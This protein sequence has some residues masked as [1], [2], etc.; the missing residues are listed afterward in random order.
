M[1]NKTRFRISL[2]YLNTPH[3]NFFFVSIMLIYSKGFYG[4]RVYLFL[5]W[6]FN[7][8]TVL[9]VDKCK[10]WRWI[11]NIHWLTTKM[12]AV[13]LLSTLST[14]CQTHSLVRRQVNIDSSSQYAK[15]PKYDASE[16]DYPQQVFNSSNGSFLAG[17]KSG[18][19]C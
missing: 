12:L 15:S 1:Q 6:F 9:T 8:P 19:F 13:V 14:I 3:H 11:W 2:K 16:L 17:F 10:W 4:K 5:W 7:L 18:N